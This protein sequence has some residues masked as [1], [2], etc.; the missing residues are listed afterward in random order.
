MSGWNQFQW[1]AWAY[2]PFWGGTSLALAGWLR[3]TGEPP[4]VRRAAYILLGLAALA[5]IISVMVVAVSTQQ[6]QGRH[7]FFGLPAIAVLVALGLER[8]RAPIAL[9]FALPALGVVGTVIAIRQ[10]VVGIYL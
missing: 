2:A 10:D 8:W 5:G 3:P 4:P 9:R 1:P 6:A 7:G